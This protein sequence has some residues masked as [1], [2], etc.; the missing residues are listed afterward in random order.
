MSCNPAAVG[1]R[2]LTANFRI[3]QL[4]DAKV[5]QLGGAVAGDEDVRGLDIAMDDQ[6][7]MGI[8]DGRAHL[9]KELESCGRVELAG[10]AEVRDVLTLHVLHREVRQA[11]A[12]RAAVQQAGNVGMLQAR[13]DLSFVAKAADDRVGVHPATQ[14]FDRDAPLKRIVIADRQKDGAH[15]ATSDLANQAVWAHRGCPTSRGRWGPLGE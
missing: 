3:E 6:V 15:A 13:Q 14:H 11:V 8:L 1:A 9:A 2:C 5:E 4:G 12:G 7:L 10:F